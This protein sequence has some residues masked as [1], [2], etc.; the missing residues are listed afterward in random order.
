MFIRSGYSAQTRKVRSSTEH[1]HHAADVVGGGRDVPR[2]A[3]AAARALRLR[4]RARAALERGRGGCCSAR[5]ALALR[6]HRLA[7]ALEHVAGVALVADRGRLRS[8]DDTVPLEDVGKRNRLPSAASNGSS[9]SAIAQRR[10]SPPGPGGGARRRRNDALPSRRRAA[11]RSASE[12]CTARSAGRARTRARR[13]RTVSTSANRQP[14]APRELIEQLGVA[15]ERRDLVTARARGRARRGPVPAPTS[16]IGPPSL[17][18]RARARA[19]GPR[20]RR[21]TRGRARSPSRRHAPPLIAQKRPRRP[22]TSE[23]L[24]Q[25]EQRRVGRHRVQPPRCRIGQGCVER[26]RQLRH[27]V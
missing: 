3:A 23:L 25:L 9:A 13:R 16:S 1:H 24:A 19:G 26:R 27:D 8:V 6:A 11:A 12:R 10:R 4:A 5:R 15:V 14:R 20:R 17:V 18:A 2:R 7:P 22:A 21:R